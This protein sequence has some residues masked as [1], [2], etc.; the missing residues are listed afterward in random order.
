M[1]FELEAMLRAGQYREVLAEA[2][3]Y[4]SNAKVTPPDMLWLTVKAAEA[5]C[6]ER[7][8]ALAVSWAERGLAVKDGNLALEGMLHFYA[9]TAMMY[10]GNLGR[11]ES[12]LLRFR[13]LAKSSPNLLRLDG[14][15]VFNLAYLHRLLRRR[16]MEVALLREAGQLYKAG[17]R[18][19]RVLACH[20]EV[21][22]SLLLSG[23]ADE[24]LAELEIAH[25]GLD[26]HGDPEIEADVDIAMAYY[27]SV[28]GDRDE[29]DRICTRLLEERELPP[30]QLADVAWIIGTNAFEAGD[31]M[32]ARR[33]V[34]V[35][36]RAAVEDWWPPQFE[37]IKALKERL[38]NRG[39][40]HV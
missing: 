12:E 16:D 20:F 17:G 34:E 35:A 26:F 9:G 33:H 6:R 39:P 10:R 7:Y 30:R 29:S 23:Q 2:E 31:T 1:R 18:N 24:A 5:A 11:A 38:T 40:A 32:T 8:W 13:D 4:Y 14:D 21:G 37:R 28:K 27:Y 25:T 36:Y 3:S 19:A 15:A 22:W